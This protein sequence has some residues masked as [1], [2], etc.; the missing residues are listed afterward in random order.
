MSCFTNS[1]CNTFHCKDLSSWTWC[2]GEEKTKRGHQGKEKTS[3]LRKEDV[4]KSR[5]QSE[6]IKLAII[7]F[8]IWVVFLASIVIYL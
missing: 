7:V 8:A 3:H 6:S 1:F 5:E 2:K 4:T